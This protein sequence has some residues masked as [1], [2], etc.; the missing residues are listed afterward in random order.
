MHIQRIIRHRDPR[1]GIVRTL[2]LIV[3]IFAC[4][5]IAGF[6]FSV[7]MYATADLIAW[8]KGWTWPLE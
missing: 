6:L 8:M 1:M 5:M 2:G 4:V 7:S 3:G